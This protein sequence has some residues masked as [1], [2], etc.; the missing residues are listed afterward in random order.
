MT[1]LPPTALSAQA[2]TLDAIFGFNARRYGETLALTDPPDRN[3]VMD[4]PPRSLTYAEADRAVDALAALLGALALP[5][6][7][8]VGIQLPNTV[9]SMVSLLAVLR[10]GLVAAP[11]PLLWRQ[12]DA[13]RALAQVGAKALIAGGRS[14]E[15]DHAE[16]AMHLAAEA[17][18]VRFVCAFGS[19]LPDDVVPLD[20]V[21]DAEGSA[22]PT[23][24]R[25]AGDDAVISFDIGEDG[26]LPARHSHAALMLAGLS[27]FVESGL[28]A[29]ARIV[30][31]MLASSFA[32]L[33]ATLAPWL[34]SGGTLA[35][36]HPF[37]AEALGAQ[38]AEGPCDALVLPGPLLPALVPALERISGTPARMLA[39]WRTPERQAANPGLN[40]D[41]P[42]PPPLTD[43]LAFRE[44]GLVALRRDDAGRPAPLRAG[45]V[46]V[47]SGTA[48]GMTVTTLGRTADGTLAFGGADTGLP[49]RLDAGGTLSLGGGPPGIVSLGGYRFAIA[50]L[51]D[52]V[53]RVASDSVLAVLPDVLAGEKLAG[54]ATDSDAM[55]AELARRGVSPLVIE[56]F[57]DR[58]QAARES[59]AA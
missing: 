37:D 34:L 28:P 30:G 33:G 14:G 17:F 19:E 12:A 26:P 3:A 9:E 10:A 25:A 20:G 8:V 23:P 32:V 41:R 16:L 11:L 46:T 43:V 55:R 1:A 6:G 15:T 49:C 59:P 39:V 7:S 42:A 50:E 18:S 13:A 27:V 40:S 4:G 21:W 44:R 51:Q 54:F 31:T 45:P 5:S 52:M 35:L 56:A 2:G 24:L 57:R 29:R 53:G 22:T 48:G 36:H 58:A 38:L 47:P